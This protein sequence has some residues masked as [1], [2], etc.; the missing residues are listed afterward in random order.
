MSEHE[1]QVVATDGASATAKVVKG[2]NILYTI[3]AHVVCR[4][5]AGNIRW[6]D[7]ALAQVVVPAGDPVPVFQAE[8]IQLIPVE[9]HK[10][11]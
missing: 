10:W 8:N 7:D 4:D 3:K 2:G 5:Q 11:E 6:E 9:G 1:E